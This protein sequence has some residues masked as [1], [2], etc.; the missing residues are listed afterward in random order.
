MPS[1]GEMRP[2]SAEEMDRLREQVKCLREKGLDVA[3]P[4]PENGGGIN[5]PFGDS[6]DSRKAMEECGMGHAGVA[7]AG[8]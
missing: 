3:D 2:P 4:D 1:G 7:V 6:E 5:L 8:G